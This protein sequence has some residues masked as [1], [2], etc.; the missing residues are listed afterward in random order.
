MRKRSY[1]RDFEKALK[2]K[3][4]LHASRKNPRLA[5]DETQ[6]IELAVLRALRKFGSEGLDPTYGLRRYIQVCVEN[7]IWRSLRD[8]HR[9]AAKD[10]KTKGLRHHKGLPSHE[11]V[12]DALLD[13]PLRESESICRE[14]LG[15]SQRCNDSRNPPI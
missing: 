5:T 3:D 14:I 1:K 4:R 15:M 12:V 11:E 13:M 6:E 2:V 10:Q 9:L 7:A 8:G